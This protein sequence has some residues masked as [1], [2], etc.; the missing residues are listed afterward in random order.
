[1]KFDIILAFSV[2]THTH[3]S[4]MLELVRHC[5]ACWPPAVYWPL[6]SPIRLMTGPLSDPRRCLQALH[7]RL[8]WE[9]LAPMKS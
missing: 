5:E 1:M 7:V 4:E 8:H 2:F 6:P 3:R 9:F